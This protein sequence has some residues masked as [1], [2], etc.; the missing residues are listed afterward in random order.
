M[1]IYIYIYI[2]GVGYTVL[3]KRVMVPRLTRCRYGMLDVYQLEVHTPLFSRCLLPK[4]ASTFIFCK[5]LHAMATKAA[6]STGSGEEAVKLKR[7]RMRRPCSIASDDKLRLLL[8]VARTRAT[9]TL[10][11]SAS[12]SSGEL[13]RH[14]H[15]RALKTPG[16]SNR[17]SASC[18][19]FRPIEEFSRRRSSSSTNRRS[20][21]T[22]LVSIATASRVS[23]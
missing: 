2:Y 15:G 3:Y 19:S 21:R 1:C 18:A 20:N 10:A 6:M 11:I 4:M 5:A 12:S 7:P 17:A 14:Q 9:N 16:S 22:A 23:A 13:G 8:P